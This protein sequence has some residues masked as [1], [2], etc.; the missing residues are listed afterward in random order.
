MNINQQTALIEM[1]RALIGALINLSGDGL[2]AQRDALKSITPY[3]IADVYNPTNQSI[4]SSVASMIVEGAICTPELLYK[5]LADRKTLDDIGG[6]GA[7]A[8]LCKDAASYSSLDAIKGLAKN[9]LEESRRRK[10]CQLTSIVQQGEADNR[11]LDDILSDAQT[12][13]T[14]LQKKQGQGKKNLIINLMDAIDDIKPREWLIRSVLPA[15]EVI[16]L[17]GVPKAGKSFIAIDW[18]LSIATGTA[19]HGYPI[20]AQGAVLYVSGEGNTN[21]AKRFKGWMTYHEVETVHN[22]MLT[23]RAYKLPIDSKQVIEDV[24]S[25]MAEYGYPSI[26][27]IFL[28]TYRRVLDGDEDSNRDANAFFDAAAIIQDRYQCAV[29]IVHHS[30][31]ADINRMT[32]ASTLGANAD[33]IYGLKGSIADGNAVILTNTHAKDSPNLPEMGFG[34]KDVYLD[35]VLADPDNPSLGFESTLVPIRAEITLGQVT[36]SYALKGKQL[37]AY[38]LLLTMQQEQSIAPSTRFD[39]A[40]EPV[41]LVDDWLRRCVLARIANEPSKVRRDILK[42]LEIKKAVIVRDQGKYLLTASAIKIAEAA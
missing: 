32:G 26:K 40:E 2:E 27:A 8:Q 24:D 42:P 6:L 23:K 30:N 21:I 16:F 13:I 17:H 4:Y 39:E 35:G 12:L 41:I 29:I 10:A 33:M 28:D 11:P 9:L 5:R 20:K 37:E 31:R 15:Q 1:E 14:S 19:W 22:V 18:A 38:N 3:S 25:S 36:T 34:F 7:I